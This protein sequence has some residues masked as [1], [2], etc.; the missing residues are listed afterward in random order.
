[1]NDGAS[2][3]SGGGLRRR[4][5]TY[6]LA[7]L[8][9]GFVAYVVPVRDRCFEPTDPPAAASG[10]NPTRAPLSR[11]PDACILHGSGGDVRLAPPACAR[12][13]C[14]PGLASTL[15]HARL[16]L[17][18]LFGLVF[19]LGTLA[20]AARW[21]S[22]LRLANVPVTVLQAWRITLES[23]AGGALLPGGVA[24]DALRIG[25]LQGLGVPTPIVVASVLL[26]RAIGLSTMSGMAAALAASF[27][28][29]A[30]GPA[31]LVLAALPLGV[32]LGLAVLRSGP[33]RRAKLLDRP[34][35]ARTAK[36]VLE[37]LSHPGASRA[38]AGSVAWS[39]LVSA[40]QLGI[41]RGLLTALDVVPTGERWVFTGSAIAFMVAVIPA[42]PGGWGTSDAAFVVFLGRAGVSA[43]AALGVAVLYRLYVYASSIAG[44]VLFVARRRQKPGPKG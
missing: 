32:T 20:W 16:G 28:P 35:L 42:L 38:I 25:S 34:I 4:A 40:V 41:L 8:A 15:A 13:D 10:A 27:D 19:A 11:E 30:V 36:P 23:M 5:L 6:G 9:V 44:A 22:L 33:M 1:M 39:L 7:I 17:L 31:V 2:G 29:G 43:S 24:G 26:D 14:E 12:L 21:H 3:D 18:A 37:Y